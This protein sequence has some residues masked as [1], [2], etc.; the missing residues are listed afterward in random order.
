MGY[1]T[2]I[3]LRNDSM[4][5]LKENPSEFVETLFNGINKANRTHKQESAGLKGHCNPIEIHPSRHADDETVYV[6]T[7]NTTINLNPYNRDME[8]L[9]KRNPKLALDFVKRAEN[10]LKM[11][12][13]KIKEHEAGS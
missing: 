4:H 13:K 8:E 12:R 7:G 9:I 2:T 1:L 6:H 5:V 10:I 3:T 11:A